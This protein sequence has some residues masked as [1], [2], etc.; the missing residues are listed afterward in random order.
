MQEAHQ[1]DALKKLMSKS[2]CDVER[3]FQQELPGGVTSDKEV[4]FMIMKRQWVKIFLGLCFPEFQ[5]KLFC[6]GV[7]TR[8]LCATT[9]GF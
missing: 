9:L 4:W 1:V 2:H 5:K 7:T 6:Q 8:H 3:L